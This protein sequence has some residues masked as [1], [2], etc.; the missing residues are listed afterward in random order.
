MAR[1]NGNLMEV[2]RRCSVSQ[3]TVSRVL[4]NSK[5]GRFSVSP[6]VREKI[7]QAARELNYRPSIAARNLTVNKTHLVAVLG[8][9]GIWSDQVGPVEEAVGAL[10]K[11]MDRA[12]YEICV[13]FISQRHGPFD[14]PPLRVDGVVAVGPQN[15]DHLQALDDTDIPYVSI[16][17]LTGKRGWQVVPDDAGGTRQALRHLVDLG[18][19]RIAYL[20]HPAMNAAHPSVM[21]R[22]RAF[23]DAAVELGFEIPAM[24][25]PR[26]GAEIP[27]D[28]IYEP[29]VK[30]AVMD[31]KA[32]AVL[33]YSHHGALALMRTAYDLGLIVPRDFSLVC[34]NNEPVV[35]LSIPSISAVDVPAIRMGQ[36]AAELLLQQMT[37]SDKLSPRS[38][39]LEE[40]LVVRESTAPPPSRR[41]L[42]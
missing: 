42:V 33:A 1:L 38:I 24:E 29:F 32:T 20:D 39:K 19:R 2:A 10:S 5:Q 41:A 27:W 15:A 13:Q 25:L 23:S 21:L 9:P 37:T 8:V 28:S 26:L 17:G 31:G 6:E 7:V 30:D 11:A 40:F 36:V 18:H 35:R 3:S 34:F 16:N 4:N 22:R 14:L 12:G